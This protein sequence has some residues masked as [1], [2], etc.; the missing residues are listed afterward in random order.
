MSAGT[1]KPVKRVH[2]RSVIK[3][4]TSDHLR[5]L[6]SERVSVDLPYSVHLMPGPRVK[7]LQPGHRIGLARAAHAYTG[8]N[9]PEDHGVRGASSVVE[10][11]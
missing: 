11:Q 5:C 6:D 4:L 3:S 9:I 8:G 10:L 7:A 1:R 2:V